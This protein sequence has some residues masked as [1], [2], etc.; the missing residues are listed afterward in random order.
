MKVGIITYHNTANY[1]AALQAYAT[2]IALSEIGIRSEIID[3]TN[4]IRKTEYAPWRKVFAQF[5]KKKIV[6]TII[7]FAAIPMIVRRNRNFKHFYKEN[8]ITSH[9]KYRKKEEIKNAPPSYDLYIAGSDQIWNWD[10]NG[11]DDNYFLDF[12]K[13]KSNTM[14]YASSFGMSNIPEDLIDKYII[15]I[16]SIRYI[17]VREQMGANLVKQLI[18]KNVETVLDPVFL[19]SKEI[20]ENLIRKESLNKKKY[21]LIYT[22]NHRYMEKFESAATFSNSYKKKIIM[23]TDFSIKQILNSNIK[24]KSSEG[25]I[26]FLRYFKNS[27]FIITSSFH[28]TAFA[29]IMEKPFIV[30]LS[31]HDGRNSRITSLLNSIGLS[32]RIF[33]PDTINDVILKKIDYNEVNTKLHTLR[34][35]SLRFIKDIIIN[36]QREE[37]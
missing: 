9:Q 6:A 18:G 3:Y 26:K 24:I 19:P 4:E 32:E 29:I 25:P 34:T 31:D 5:K 8:L 28:G 12:V 20:W 37:K 35:H 10:G 15:L 1:G 33:D 22:N 2:Q 11:N 23:G 30:F 36:L 7:T 27:D 16:K 13:D 14:S 17:S 21:M